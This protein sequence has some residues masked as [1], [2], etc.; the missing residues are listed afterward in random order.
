[1]DIHSVNQTGKIS[2]SYQAERPIA[3]S[4]GEP[5]PFQEASGEPSPE[6]NTSKK[7]V[8]KAVD[9][10]NKWLQT[11]ST[12]LKFTLHEK[13]NEYY[14]EIVDDQTQEVIREV[15]PKKILDMVA[16]MHEMIGILVDEK[17]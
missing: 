11:G 14:V 2:S 15:P 7:E 8:E 9:S 5:I 1:M 13:L 17:R 3:T 16:K 10:L 6:G 12:H 4:S